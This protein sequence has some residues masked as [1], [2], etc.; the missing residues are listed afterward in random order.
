MNDRNLTGQGGCGGIVSAVLIAIVLG[1]LAWVTRAD[2]AGLD[3]PITVGGVL[4]FIGIVGG[5][6][7]LTA[8]CFFVLWL[9]NP[10]R[11]GN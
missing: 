4:G 6:L 2:A 1:V 11:T 10:F 5:A 8:L 9:F 7:A 3:A